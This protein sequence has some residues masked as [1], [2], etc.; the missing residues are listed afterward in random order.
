MMLELST[1]I[2]F[3]FPQETSGSMENF[4]QKYL[5]SESLT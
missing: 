3:R 4:N 1:T 2:L 5:M